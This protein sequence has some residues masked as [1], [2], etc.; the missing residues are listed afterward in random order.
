[1]DTKNKADCSHAMV[2][3]DG[4]WDGINEISKER[5][6]GPVAFCKECGKKLYLSQEEWNKIPEQNREG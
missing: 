1:M 5:I 2:K 6:G 3:R 4:L